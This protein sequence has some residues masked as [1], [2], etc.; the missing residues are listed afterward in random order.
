VRPQD[1]VIITLLGA[2]FSATALIIIDNIHN[3]SSQCKHIF[4]DFLIALEKHIGYII[5]SSVA[6]VCIPSDAHQRDRKKFNI[7]R[8]TLIGWPPHKPYCREFAS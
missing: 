3:V 7:W 6:V 1:S 4:D 5:N 8:D 2:S